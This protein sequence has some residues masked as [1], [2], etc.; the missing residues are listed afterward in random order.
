MAP[1]PVPW[2]LRVKMPGAYVARLTGSAELFWPAS[3]A[4]RGAELPD[5]SQGI[6]RFT[7]P[8]PA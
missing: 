5:N 2:P 4:V 1:A 6:C 8:L 7:C 3:V